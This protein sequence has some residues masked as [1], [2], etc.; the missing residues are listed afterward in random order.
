MKKLAVLLIIFIAV[1]FGIGNKTYADYEGHMYGESIIDCGY[2][3][4]TP[5]DEEWSNFE[6]TQEM[7]E[8]C[9][10]DGE[11]L[12]NMTTVELVD[13]V[14][15]YPLMVNIYAYDSFEKGIEI[16]VKHFNGLEELVSRNDMI[17][18][19]CKYMEHI[20]DRE[21]TEDLRMNFGIKCDYCIFLL[22]YGRSKSM[23]ISNETAERIIDIYTSIKNMTDDGTVSEGI[24]KIEYLRDM[25]EAFYL[26]DNNK[27][28]TQI[29][30]SYALIYADVS[31]AIKKV[32]SG[33]ISTPK[34]TKM[35]LMKYE[36]VNPGAVSYIDEQMAKA[37]PNATRLRSASA[38]YNCHSYAWYS[39][40]AGNKYWMEPED[41]ML[42]I[43]DGSY[44]MVTSAA[45]IMTGT[46]VQYI[47]MSES[48]P[49]I[50]S[51]VVYSRNSI[52]FSFLIKGIGLTVNS[53][54]GRAGLYRHSGSYSPYEADALYFF[55]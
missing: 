18:G 29:E 52:N 31:T 48:P 37:Y 11:L 38:N 36:F 1:A 49:F 25:G 22:D 32:G 45:G 16:L 24:I 9:Q 43:S 51:A 28:Q 13:A 26:K 21:I 15:N 55:S 14:V 46:K 5:E 54:W 42:Y 35:T 47:D 39:S 12:N 2:Y 19:I 23:N 40:S 53:K 4:I 10:L 27:I 3:E 34:G 41:A 20:S 50:H 7:Y 17:D 8:A 44:T 33:V 30:E 6:T